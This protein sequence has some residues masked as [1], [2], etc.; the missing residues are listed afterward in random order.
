VN[1]DGFADL[2]V[3]APQAG[4]VFV[5]LGS[6]GG[7]T[8]G[9]RLTIDAPASIGT[10]FGTTLAGLGDVNG[11]GFDDLLIGAPAAGAAAVYLGCTTGIGTTAAVTFGPEADLGTAVSALGDV[12]LD[13]YDDFAITVPTGVRPSRLDVFAGGT[14]LST[15][16][17]ATLS[18]LG[19]NSIGADTAS[20]GVDVN[21]D[22]YAD[23]VSAAPGVPWPTE[24]LMVHGA[25]RVFFGRVT[26]VDPLFSQVLGGDIAVGCGDSCR[27]PAVVAS[28]GDLDG[29]GYGDIAVANSGVLSIPP[30]A[31]GLLF[32]GADG[33]RASR[34]RGIG[35][36]MGL[37]LD[38]ACAGDMDGDGFLDVVAGVDYRAP[39]FPPNDDGRAM[40]FRGA[41][42]GALGGP[43]IT[44]DPPMLNALFGRSVAALS[45]QRGP[46]GGLLRPALR[47]FPNS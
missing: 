13:G 5:Y 1:N 41:S 40:I 36:P 3:G 28:L 17:M 31:L 42:G 9:S 23:V 20:G 8:P 19:T 11:D 43:S 10:T 25:V 37:G 29:D 14:S 21:G 15:T 47:G 35:G 7:L 30:S 16:P 2:A 45:L 32:G 44:L 22:G 38:F 27:F 26:G 33:V 46:C 12:N 18:G 24:P 39:A 4:R 6:V 34:S